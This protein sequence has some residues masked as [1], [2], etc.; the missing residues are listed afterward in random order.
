[1]NQ[2]PP[3]LRARYRLSAL[4][5]LSMLILLATLGNP[6]DWAVPVASAQNQTVPP[7]TNAIYLPTIY[8]NSCEQ[9]LVATLEENSGFSTLLRTI[10]AANLTTA[11]E[12]VGP[13]TLFAPTDAAFEGLPS[14]ALDQLLA[15]PTG[16]L[17]QILLFHIVPGHIE[18]DD[19]QNGAQFVTQQGKM[20][21]VERNSNC[22]I[23]INGARFHTSN[24]KASNGII[25]AIDTVLLPPPD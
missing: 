25:H 10:E 9:N 24:L 16:Q 23:R 1:M 3:L 19:L 21:T 2:T 17:T 18:I 5:W 13:Y 8:G 12:G 11:L 6:I 14:S 7:N 15:N 20:L 4:F 22:D